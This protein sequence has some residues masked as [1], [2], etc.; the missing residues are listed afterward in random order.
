[1]H[2][3]SECIHKTPRLQEQRQKAYNLEALALPGTRGPAAQGSMPQAWRGA[4]D[5]LMHQPLFPA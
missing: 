5:Q 3:L 1:M 4:G 2:W